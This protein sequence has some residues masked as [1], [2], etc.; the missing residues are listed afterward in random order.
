M[1]TFELLINPLFDVER[2][3]NQHVVLTGKVMSGCV[4]MVTV[5]VP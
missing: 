2:H 4:S 5:F 3:L 1:V